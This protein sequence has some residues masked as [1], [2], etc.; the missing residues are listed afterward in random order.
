MAFKRYAIHWVNLDPVR[1]S[2]LRKVR[3]WRDREH[4]R[5]EPRL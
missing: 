1:G 4:G 5:A 3:P 2:E